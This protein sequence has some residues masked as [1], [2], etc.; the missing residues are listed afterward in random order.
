VHPAAVT[1]VM[2]LSGT[3]VRGDLRAVFQASGE[4]P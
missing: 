4:A 1:H 2:I 3:P